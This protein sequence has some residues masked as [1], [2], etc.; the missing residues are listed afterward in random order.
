M[1]WDLWER[2]LY[3]CA[4]HEVAFLW[5]RGHAGDPENERCDALSVQAAQGKDLPPDLLFESSH[6]PRQGILLSIYCQ[7]PQMRGF[8]PRDS[9]K[10]QL[11]DIPER[12]GTLGSKI[13]KRNT[14]PQTGTP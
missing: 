6:F 1:N 9:P 5:V 11:S 4:R 14:Y 7:V 13:F 12:S 3:E 8:N 2:L 10:Q